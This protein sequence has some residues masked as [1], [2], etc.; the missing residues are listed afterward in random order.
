MLERLKRFKI[1]LL[2]NTARAALRFD[3]RLLIGVGVICTV[4]TVSMYVLEGLAAR[5]DTSRSDTI[6]RMRLSSP[7]PSRDIII[8]DIDERSLALLAKKHGNWPWSRELQAEGLQK[9]I[10][11]NPKAVLFSVML[12][13]RNPQHPDADAAM[14]ITASLAKNVA[15]PMI[16]LNPDND[17]ESKL[18]VT[19]IPDALLS[20]GTPRDRTLAIILPAFPPMHTRMGVGNPMLDNDGIVRKYP[21]RWTEPDFTLPSIVIKT[22]EAAGLDTQDLPN[23]FTINWRNKRG[24][25]QRISFV[26]LLEI[27]PES[28]EAKAIRNAYVVVG[29]SAPGIGQTKPTAISAVMDDNEIFATA[30]DDAIHKTYL[31]TPPDWLLLILTIAGSWGLVY[32]AIRRTTANQ[33]TTIFVYAQAALGGVML[34]GA[35]YANYLIDLS[36]TMFYL[37]I[38]FTA[39][40]LICTFGHASAAAVPGYRKSDINPTAR[41]L[42]LIG[43][44]KD[45]MLATKITD[46]EKHLFEAVGINNVIRIDDLFGGHNFLASQMEKYVAFVVLADDA[47]QLSVEATLMADDSTRLKIH[48][49]DLPV[50]TDI[51]GDVFRARVTGLLTA[52]AAALFSA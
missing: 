50:G 39:I 25:Y 36:S 6:L 48:R 49:A 34:I 28:H 20:E 17:G 40:K 13:D 7:K 29:L 47:Q 44:R 12:S 52:N 32:L 3:V 42:V 22:L 19:Q 30:L 2:S 27:D 38:V 43:M 16:R 33:I 5:S 8:V 18:K 10:D 46:I 35:S 4:A 51:E 1:D 11:A 15:Y 26:D 45:Q 9:L 14:E 21:L 23:S 31:R 24:R 37:L 41:H